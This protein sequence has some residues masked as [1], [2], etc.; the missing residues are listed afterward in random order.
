MCVVEWMQKKTKM[1]GSS[2]GPWTWSLVHEKLPT[3]HLL[4]LLRGLWKPR[5][6]AT[7]EQM[8]DLEGKEGGYVIIGYF[9]SFWS[10]LQLSARP[11]H[12]SWA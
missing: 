5:C 11:N 9:E 1:K 6:A 10:F 2:Q 12:Q 4:N 7:E 3:H 8:E